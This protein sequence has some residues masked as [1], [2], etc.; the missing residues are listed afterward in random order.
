MKKLFTMILCLVFTFSVKSFSQTDPD[1]LLLKNYRPKSIYHI[2]VTI[3]AHAKYPVIDMHSHPY[4]SSAAEIDSWVKTMDEMG[5]EKTIIFTYETGAGFDSVVN[6][7]SKYKDRFE[8]WCGFDYTGYDKPGFGP[9]AVKE[10][11]HCY[12]MGAKGVGELGDKGAGEL[13]S[14]PVKGYGL[15][16]D[17]PRMKPLLEK[18]A[19]LHMPINIHVAEDYWM[20]EKPDSTNDGMM[21]AG[22]WHVDVTG[23]KL[24][25]QQ[26]IQ[27]LENAVRDNPKTLF[28]AAHFANL[29]YNLD[30]AGRLLDK[31]PNLYLDIA[32]RYAE[33]A[34]IP[35]YMAG[36]YS[37]YQD[38]L[39][40]GTDMGMD[41]HM[42]QTT[43]R[44]LE[45]SDEHFY[46]T[47]MF[48][49]HWSYSGFSLDNKILKKI[50]KTNAL[51]IRKYENEGK[52]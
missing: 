27:S 42:Y 20:F 3:P 33:T 22:V 37:K 11:E 8:L 21:N 18:C 2:P 1:H 45:T 9:A 23:D 5:I 13:Y 52:L 12:K 10:L 17:D 25:H 41:K 38:R 40:Y 6:A 35:R 43:F 36:F 51:R 48:N 24:N 19:E 30:E 7:Y 39:I 34:T 16:I 31:Y 29:C 14:K 49:Y 46:E 4:A 32:A 44:I 50:Y 28:I 26:L 47:E 15:H